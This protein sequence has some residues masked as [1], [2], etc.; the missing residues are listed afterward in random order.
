[1][2]TSLSAQAT[3]G[4]IAP[5]RRANLAFA[6]RHPGETLRRQPVHTVYGGAH[7]FQA[8]TAARLGRAALQALEEYAPDASTFARAIGLPAQLA[9]S[10]YARVQEK[11]RREPVEDFRID[12]EDGYGNRSDAEEDGHAEAA[13][14]EI[15]RAMAAESLPPFVGIRIKPFSEES[16]GRSIRTLDIFVSTLVAQTHRKLP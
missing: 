2:K 13:A 12:F 6:Q 3:R 16:R 5:L 15:A 9:E 10:I 4:L 11:L 1:M 7:L 8:D 14:L